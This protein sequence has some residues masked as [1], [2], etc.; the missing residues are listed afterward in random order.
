V[1][2]LIGSVSVALTLKCI[3][4]RAVSEI[5]GVAGNE[6][7][8]GTEADDPAQPADGKATTTT[9]L[10]TDHA[11]LRRISTLP[12]GYHPPTPRIDYTG[13]LARLFGKNIAGRRKPPGR[14]PIN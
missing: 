1:N 5:S 9:P 6:D 4:A 13:R 3:C 12:Q 11:I 10:Q 2:P 8:A 7:V 14:E